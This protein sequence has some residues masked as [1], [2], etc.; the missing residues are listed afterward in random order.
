MFLENL[1][2]L[3]VVLRAHTS[4]YNRRLHDGVNTLYHTL[5]GV[6]TLG[7]T[8]VEDP[9]SLSLWPKQLQPE[10]VFVPVKYEHPVI[11]LKGTLLTPKGPQKNS[12]QL[13]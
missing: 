7:F 6:Y 13:G 12:L 2:E 3:L 8:P 1:L 4:A 9:A 10:A 11:R 5:A